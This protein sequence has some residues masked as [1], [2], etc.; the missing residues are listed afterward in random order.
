MPYASIQGRALRHGHQPEQHSMKTP[1]PFIPV[2][3]PAGPITAALVPD[4]ARLS[5]LPRFFGAKLTQAELLVYRWMDALCE[6]YSGGYWQF[7]ALSNGGF[8]MA[9]SRTQRMRLA[10]GGNAFDGEMSARAAGIV[11]CLFAFG[12]LAQDETGG[13][14]FIGLYHLLRD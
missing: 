3:F 14:R 5:T 13:E 1:V 11:A 2:P 4:E 12:E 10:V 8:Y 9:P 6:A 7:Y